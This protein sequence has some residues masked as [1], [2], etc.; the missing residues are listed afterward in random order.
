MPIGNRVIVT[1]LYSSGVKVAELS[2]LKSEQV[3]FTNG[4]VRIPK[5]NAKTEESRTV[6]IGKEV[7]SDIKDLLRLEK[8]KKA[9]FLDRDRGGTYHQKD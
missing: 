5:E 3:D 8:G 6:R 4:F 9:I 7:L 1:L 2:L